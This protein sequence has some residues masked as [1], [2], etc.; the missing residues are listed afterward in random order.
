VNEVIVC[1]NKHQHTWN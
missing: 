1:Q